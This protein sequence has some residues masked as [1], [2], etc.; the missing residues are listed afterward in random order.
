MSQPVG[1][2]KAPRPGAGEHEPKGNFTHRLYTGEFEF[3]FVPHARRWYTIS[4]IL[5]LISV[6]ALFTR[7]LNLGIDFKGGSVF[8]VPVS[9]VSSQTVPDFKQVLT[10]SAVPNLEGYEVTTVG[11]DS[12]RIQTR[13]LGNDEVSTLRHELAD[14]AQTTPEKVNYSLIGPSWGQQITDKALQAL[15]VFLVLVGLMIWLFFREWRMSVSALV[16]LGHDLLVTVGFYALV[17]FTVT[18]ATLIGVLTILGYSL[19]D[20]VVVFDK[21]RENTREI[22]K[23]DRTFSEAANVA[24]NQVLVRSINTTLI[25]ILPVLALLIAGIGF[26]GG[27]G[28]LA[29]LGLALLIGMVTGAYSSIFIATPLLA[30]LRE[31]EPAMKRHVASLERRRSRSAAKVSVTTTVATG[32]HTPSQLSGATLP[33]TLQPG[34]RTQPVHKT[35]SQRRK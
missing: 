34:T 19:Y 8:T 27:E 20:T 33:T 26:L 6:V 25:G 24:V 9:S 32:E 22:T 10:R 17:G 28:P 11:G 4:A 5:L 18:P 31:A 29:D 1:T 2:D 16:A 12:V 13:S 7:G 3:S 30:Q 35:R 21:V 23:Q 14:S 15:V